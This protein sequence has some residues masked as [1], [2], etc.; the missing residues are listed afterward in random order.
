MAQTVAIYWAERLQALARARVPAA[1]PPL[2][3]VALTHFA[4]SSTTPQEKVGTLVETLAEL[5]RDFGTWKIPWGDV[6]RFQRLTGHVVETYDD[7]QPSLPVAFTSANWGSLASFKAQAYPGTKKRYG[8]IGNSFVAV[9]DFGPR[10][11]ARSVMTGG[12][13]SRPGTPHF[14]DQ[15]ALY[16][17][18]QFKEV[19]FYPEDVQANAE[20]TYHPGQ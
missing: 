5:T 1:Q 7:R 6:N 13:S 9:V 11:V 15:A 17:K 3:F 10:I 2:D 16:C 12:Q 4:V 19:R 18:G 20:K 14:T 8:D